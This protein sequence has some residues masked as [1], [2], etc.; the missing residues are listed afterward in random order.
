M[1]RWVFPAIDFCSYGQNGKADESL[2]AGVESGALSS[3][4]LKC[5]L[6]WRMTLENVS[7]SRRFILYSHTTHT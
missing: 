3:S 6:F 4:P 2:F 7:E 1:A 5:V